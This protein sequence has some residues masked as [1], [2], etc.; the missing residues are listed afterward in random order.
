LQLEVR[1]ALEIIDTHAY[2]KQPSAS[3]ISDAQAGAFAALRL[4]LVR[5]SFDVDERFAAI[6]RRF[7]AVDRRFD[8]MERRFDAMDVRF[9]AMDR[10]FDESEVRLD[11]RFAEFEARIE[12][13][14][15]KKLETQRADL[16]KWMFGFFV[17]NLAA[18]FAMFSYMT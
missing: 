14:F 2:I 10:R 3:G 15:D 11:R 4:E 17:T 13:K 7:D 18:T 16:I 1:I 5:F 6:D 9:D 12:A 8:V